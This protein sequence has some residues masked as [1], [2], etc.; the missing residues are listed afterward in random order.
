MF[1]H[2]HIEAVLLGKGCRAQRTLIGLDPCVDTFVRVQ[3]ALPS[4]G[5]TTLIAGELTDLCVDDHVPAALFFRPKQIGTNWAPE[6][7]D[8]LMKA[9]DVIP[10]TTTSEEA[11]GTNITHI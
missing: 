4:E 3:V 10:Q 5:L 11:F 2:V 6:S 8:S 7:L 9:Y 1:L